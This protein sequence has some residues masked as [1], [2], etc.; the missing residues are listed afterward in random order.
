MWFGV[1]LRDYIVNWPIIK[2]Q[3]TERCCFDMMND[4]NPCRSLACFLRI[5]CRRIIAAWLVFMGTLK[6]SVPGA[7]HII[8]FLHTLTSDRRVTGSFSKVQFWLACPYCSDPG[9]MVVED[10]SQPRGGRVHRI[11][12]CTEDA[13]AM[14]LWLNCLWGK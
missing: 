13:A 8:S 2:G 1:L 4:V 10:P 14:R 12:L 9:T 3:P 5:F 11:G 7:G 6:L